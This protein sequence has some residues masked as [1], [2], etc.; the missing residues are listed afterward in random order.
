M[1]LSADAVASGRA[2]E[3]NAVPGP[4][5][6]LGAP[7]VGKGTQAKELVKLWGIPQ[8]S[9]GDLLRGN[10]AQGTDLG[11]AA[12]EI[13]GRGDLVPDSLVE[14]MVAVRLQQP[15]T[16]KGYILDGFPRTLGQADW[17]DGKL[18]SRTEG[19]PV[20]AVSIR[21]NYNQL[22][23]RITGRRN[24]PVCQTIYNVYLNPPKREGFC[25][26]EG[27][28]LSQRADDTEEVFRERMLTYEAQTAPV[29]E[30]YRALGRFAEVDGD[31]PIA[32]VAAGIVAAVERLRK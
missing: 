11:K 5:L 1:S 26:V 4:I 18:G 28:A 25:D 29:V 10:V 6:L 20:V 31:R 32:E 16:R 9:T 23:R 2:A 22:L 19:L 14:E 30:H 17:L 24:C 7:G 27:A 3:S 8:I 21:V 13:M 12:K 15:D